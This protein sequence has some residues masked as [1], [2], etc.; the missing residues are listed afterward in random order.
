MAEENTPRK[1]DPN[2]LPPISPRSLP[3]LSKPKKKKR[4]VNKS[5]GE[6]NNSFAKSPGSDL[7]PD[8]DKLQTEEIF[9][10]PSNRVLP[11]IQTSLSSPENVSNESQMSEKRKKKKKVPC[12]FLFFFNQNVLKFFLIDTMS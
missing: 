7:S 3:S 4:T 10:S 11:P 2:K 1:N 12:Y 9:K 6:V 5:N 8:P